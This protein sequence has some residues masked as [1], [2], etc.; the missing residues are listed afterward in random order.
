MHVSRICNQY[1]SLESTWGLCVVDLF[2]MDTV[3]C[4]GP[5]LYMQGGTSCQEFSSGSHIKILEPTN[6]FRFKGMHTS[7][8]TCL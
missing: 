6:S 7:A 2:A 1:F 3:L 5:Q 8:K 4:S